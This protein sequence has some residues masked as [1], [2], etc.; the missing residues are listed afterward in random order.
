MFTS[1]TIITKLVRQMQIFQKKEV[2]QMR[3]LTGNQKIIAE[4]YI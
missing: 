4:A 2:R 1:P 3:W